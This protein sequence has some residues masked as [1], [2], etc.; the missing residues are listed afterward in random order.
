MLVIT[1]SSNLYYEGDAHIFMIHNGGMKYAQ[2]NINIL[3]TA[4]GASNYTRLVMD[5]NAI[6]PYVSIMPYDSFIIAGTS[7][8]PFRTL[9]TSKEALYIS[10]QQISFYPTESSVNLHTNINA[11]SN[12]LVSGNPLI[13]IGTMFPYAG[14]NVLPDD[15]LWCDGSTYQRIGQYAGLFA[16]IGTTYGAGDGVNTFTIPDMRRRTPM[17]RGT[18]TGLTERKLGQMIGQSSILLT[19]TNLP[20][21]THRVTYDPADRISQGDTYALIKRSTT[22]ETTTYANASIGTVGSG[23]RPDMTT[24]PYGFL[25]TSFPV[26][27]PVT[28]QS[29]YTNLEHPYCITQ[30]IIKYR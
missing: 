19:P 9:Y 18:G 2:N 21:H 16:I 28:S 22:G 20:A 1:N 24:V 14:L 15:Y 27:G 3:D 17:G 8:L 6:R 13:P 12:V 25:T 30:Y 23:N 26:G 4:L 29:S 11:C 5:S 7:N 10:D